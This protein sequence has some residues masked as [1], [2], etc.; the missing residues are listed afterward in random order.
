MGCE[1]EI[2]ITTSDPEVIS[3][4]KSVKTST[5]SGFDLIF[6]E[7]LV[8]NKTCLVNLK[9]KCQLNCSGS[10]DGKHGYFMM[11]RSSIYKE[12]IRQSNGIGLID[13]EYRG[14]ISAP[15]DLH[16]VEQYN[17]EKGKRL[18]QIVMPSLRPFKVKIVDE[19]TTTERGEKGFGSSGQY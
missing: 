10:C 11:P 13:Y 19:L 3:Y 17:V 6:P 16:E 7:S 12:N 2:Q 8:V 5:N 4:Y 1:L 18:F 15:V 14:E 9:V